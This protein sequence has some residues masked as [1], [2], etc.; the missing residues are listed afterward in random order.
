MN[1]V[2]GLKRSREAKLPHEIFKNNTNVHLSKSLNVTAITED[3][4]SL[5][6]KG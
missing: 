1:S 2:Y 6:F 4:F 5:Y 3:L